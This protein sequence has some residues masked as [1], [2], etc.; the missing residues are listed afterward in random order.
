MLSSLDQT[1]MQI[2]VMGLIPNI[3]LFNENSN[4]SAIGRMYHIVNF[5]QSKAGLIFFLTKAK[6]SS[7]RYIFSRAEEKERWVHVFLKGINANRLWITAVRFKFHT[8]L[9]LP[10]K[11]TNC[12]KVGARAT[13][14][15]H[16][17]QNPK[18][19]IKIN[20]LDDISILNVNK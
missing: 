5:K 9:F 13:D 19:K 15:V 6:E 10:D 4:V 12:L 17:N 20:C 1:Y 7:L 8:C 16:K 18:F 11:F 2:T 3:R 14:C